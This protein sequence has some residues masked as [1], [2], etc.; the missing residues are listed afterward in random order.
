ML[1]NAT[2]GVAR[3]CM[4]QRYVALQGGGGGGG[5]GGVGWGGGGVIS[6]YPVDLLLYKMGYR[7]PETVYAAIAVICHSDTDIL[8]AF[9]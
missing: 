6:F 9:R 4:T 2:S 5:G 8:S 1:R 3:G 7:Y